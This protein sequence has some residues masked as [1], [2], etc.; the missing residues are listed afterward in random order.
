METDDPGLLA[1][2]M[3]GWRDLIDFEVHRVMTSPEAVAAI[4]PRL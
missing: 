2:W 4:S 3:A 1:E